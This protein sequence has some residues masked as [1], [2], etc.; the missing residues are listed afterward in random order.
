MKDARFLKPDLL[1][2]IRASGCDENSQELFDVT[3]VEA[4]EKKWLSGPLTPRE[5]D[6]R[7]GGTWLPVR[8]FAFQ[9]RGKL[10]PID[11]LKENHVNDA[12]SS[13]ERASL[14]AMDHLVWL[15]IFLCRF[16]RHGGEVSFELTGGTILR[17]VLSIASGWRLELISGLRR[18]ISS[19]HTSSFL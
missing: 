1:G 14:Y 18:W 4:S 11:D 2:K 16:Y 15:T 3:M 19:Q 10:R 8:R 13:T 5:V 9:Q 12:F 7:F 17:E 6:E